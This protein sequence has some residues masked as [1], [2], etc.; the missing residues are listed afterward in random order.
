ME[1]KLVEEKHPE[2]P[3]N[4]DCATKE[5]PQR[6]ERGENPQH[7]QVGYIILL[8]FE[9]K[10]GILSTLLTPSM[11]EGKQIYPSFALRIF[12]LD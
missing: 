12:I 10:K 3:L 9:G 4:S 8:P 5:N 6:L 11:K 7:C 2:E 1:K